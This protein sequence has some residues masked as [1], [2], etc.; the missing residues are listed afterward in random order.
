M[1]LGPE[2]ASAANQSANFFVISFLR[3]LLGFAWFLVLVFIE[4]LRPVSCRAVTAV[5]LRDLLKKRKL[6]SK[7][8]VA[9]NYRRVLS[10]KVYSGKNRCFGLGA[11][12][13]VGCLRPLA[14][15][16]FPPVPA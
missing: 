9:K 5:I 4:R 15:R 7:R 8:S 13:G 12:A 10:R 1:A 11:G 14:F 16:R 6:S 3:P 2:R